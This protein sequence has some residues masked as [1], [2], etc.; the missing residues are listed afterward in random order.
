[1]TK[2]KR[3]K[4]RK[5]AKRLD[6]ADYNAWVEAAHDTIVG[7]HDYPN[8]KSAKDIATLSKED[9]KDYYATLLRIKRK[10]NKITSVLGRTMKLRGEAKQRVDSLTWAL[11]RC[12]ERMHVLGLPR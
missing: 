2:V 7:L 11:Y 12:R 3:H 10:L 9:V 1:M 4:R 6:D 5:R 8:I